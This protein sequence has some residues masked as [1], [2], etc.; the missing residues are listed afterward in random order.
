MNF[1]Q[2]LRQCLKGE[3]RT[4]SLGCYACG[5]GTY[6]TYDFSDANY[7]GTVGCA[8]CPIGAQCKGYYF[9]GA[10]AGYWKFD[11]FSS[12]IFSCYNGAACAGAYLDNI[13]DHFCKDLAENY[14]GFCFNGWCGEGYTGILCEDCADGW[15]QSDPNKR[16]CVKCNDNPGYYVKR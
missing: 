10:D 1:S 12:T 15:A 14:I 4:D 13:T 8:N 6:S 2:S 5:E 11:S 7:S 9:I 16:A 3:K